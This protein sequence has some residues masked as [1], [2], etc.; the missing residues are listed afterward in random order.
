M[1]FSEDTET[2]TK[3][4]QCKAFGILYVVEPGAMM[5]VMG[6]AIQAVWRL[7]TWDAGLARHLREE[8]AC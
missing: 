5:S 1:L 3:I 4:I 2:K 8:L 7:P 6:Q